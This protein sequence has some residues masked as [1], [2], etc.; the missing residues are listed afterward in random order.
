MFIS[1]GIVH[2]L[3][4][5]YVGVSPTF[6]GGYSFDTTDCR[7]TKSIPFD[8]SALPAAWVYR[9]AHGGDFAR[10]CWLAPVVTVRMR[11]TMSGSGAPRSARLVVLNGVR[12]RPVA[13]VEWS[14]TL[15]RARVSTALCPGIPSF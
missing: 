15:L 3:R 14:P 7:A 11:V 10:Q 2:I 1:Q 9:G 8:P 13:Y 6:K 4:T 5:P 12:L